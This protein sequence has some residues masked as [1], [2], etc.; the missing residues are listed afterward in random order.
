MES[1]WECRN[2]ILQLIERS[3]DALTTRLLEFKLD[4]KLL[5]R[6]CDRFIIDNHS[7]QDVIKW[8]LQRKK[9]YAS[10]LERL[11]KI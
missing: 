11:H 8:P 1:L 4:S 2:N 6:S 3:R 5:L 9:A 10:F 7:G